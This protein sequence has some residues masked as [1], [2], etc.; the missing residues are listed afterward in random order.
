MDVGYLLNSLPVWHLRSAPLGVLFLFQDFIQGPHCI[1][2]E[3]LG[4]LWPRI[5]FQSFLVSHELHAL[6]EEGSGTLWTVPQSGFV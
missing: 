4:L 6:E 2:I 5:T 1:V 3:P